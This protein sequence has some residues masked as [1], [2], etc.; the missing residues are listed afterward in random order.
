MV[1][2]PD[3]TNSASGA[4][5]QDRLGDW[6]CGF[7]LEEMFDLPDLEIYTPV[8]VD[9]SSLRFDLEDIFDLPDMAIQ[10]PATANASSLKFDLEDIFDL[11]NWEICQLTSQHL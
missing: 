6:Q 7:D 10:V 5:F 1:G 11:P 3:R 2:K 8:A 9:K 4:P